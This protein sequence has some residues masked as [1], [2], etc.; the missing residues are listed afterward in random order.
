MEELPLLMR[1]WMI[2][3]LCFGDDFGRE[4]K[5]GTSYFLLREW[6]DAFLVC[7][8]YEEDINGLLGLVG[9][10]G[11]VATL[12]DKCVL[13]QPCLAVLMCRIK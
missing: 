13:D 4:W 10:F 12:H 1:P 2:R 6:G 8:L 7:S 5:S 3:N 9:W 11:K